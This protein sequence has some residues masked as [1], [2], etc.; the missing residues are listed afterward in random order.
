MLTYSNESYLELE[1][2]HIDNAHVSGN[3][4]ANEID[5]TDTNVFEYEFNLAYVPRTFVTTKRVH[6]SLPEFTFTRILGDYLDDCHTYQFPLPIDVTIIIEN[7]EGNVVQVISGLSQSYDFINSE[8]IFE[9]FNFD[10]YLD[11]RLLRW[12]EGAHQLNTANYFWLWDTE[13]SRYVLN[14]QL[15]MIGGVTELRTN[16]D[17]LK[18]ETWLRVNVYGGIFS[19]YEYYN[20]EYILV[21]SEFR[22]H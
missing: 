14:K 5:Y 1:V 22:K 4:L 18:I 17:T 7:D 6:E 3:Y 16:P 20:G 8:I 13:K 12:Q 9:D 19:Y 11:M 2:E 10:G 21:S 15:M